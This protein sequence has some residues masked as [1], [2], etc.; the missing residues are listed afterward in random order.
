MKRQVLTKYCH[1]HELC[2]HTSPECRILAEGH[3]NDASL[4]NRMGDS[5]H[6]II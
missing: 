5:T 1:T 2:N 3:Q 6:N 4:Q